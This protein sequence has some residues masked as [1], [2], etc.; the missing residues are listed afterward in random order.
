MTSVSSG[1]DFADDIFAA[2]LKTN[3]GSIST[4]FY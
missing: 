1:D 4:T 2:L 3:L